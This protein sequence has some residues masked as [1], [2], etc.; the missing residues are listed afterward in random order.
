MDCYFHE[1]YL[2]SL[3]LS[4]F[5]SLVPHQGR[6]FH[7]HVKKRAS[8]VCYFHRILIISGKNKGGDRRTPR[9]FWEHRQLNSP[10]CGL[11][12]A[13]FCQRLLGF[14][15]HSDKIFPEQ[16]SGPAW[17]ARPIIYGLCTHRL[18]WHYS[19]CFSLNPEMNRSRG[20]QYLQ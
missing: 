7:L 12:L 1:P 14:A 6:Y 11:A 15:P 3:L 5:I 4:A 8:S 9:C 13:W 16:I 18:S 19:H 2:R 10:F 20:F 17:Q